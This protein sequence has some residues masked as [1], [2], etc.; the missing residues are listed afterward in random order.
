MPTVCFRG[1]CLTGP[2]HSGAELHG[3]LSYIARQSARAARTGSSATA[4]NKCATTFTRST[5]A[6]RC[7]R[8]PNS[9][10]PGAVYN[11]GGGRANS[12]SLLEAVSALEEL[13]GRKLETEYIDQ[14]GGDHICYIS[15]LRRF[16]ADYPE[17]ELSVTL[18]AILEQLAST[19]V[20]RLDG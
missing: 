7:W 9:P 20:E 4:A 16:R 17:W 2:Q 12:I 8:S 19:V 1:G 11:L 14:R 3:F 5:C 18:D 10:I 15:D 6:P 13:L